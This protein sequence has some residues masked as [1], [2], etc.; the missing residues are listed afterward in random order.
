MD[1]VPADVLEDG[2]GDTPGTHRLLG[3]LDG[4]VDNFEAADA[5]LAGVYGSGEDISDYAGET[6]Q[7][8]RLTARTI[9]G[10]Y[11]LLVGTNDSSAGVILSTSGLN[12][13]S[14]RGDTFEFRI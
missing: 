4:T 10:D 11:E 12:D 5:F 14:S 7:F 13:Y 9:D 6:S 1:E 2:R 3:E 8:K